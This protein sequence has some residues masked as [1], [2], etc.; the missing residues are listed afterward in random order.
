MEKLTKVEFTNLERIMFPV[1]GST[2]SQVIEYYIKIAP[3]I[4]NYL[5]GR[6]LT[7]KRF[8]GGIAQEGFYEK[9]APAGTPPWVNTFRNASKSA[10]RDVN[11]IIC[12]DLDTLIWLANLAALE[13]NITLSKVDSYENPDMVFIDMDPE[14]P[15]TFQDTCQAAILLKEKLDSLDFKSYIK[16]SGKK[17]VHVVIPI[18]EKYS[19]KQTRGFVHTLGRYLAKE[20]DFIVSEFSRSREPGTIFIDYTLNVRGKTMA[21]PYSL[22]PEEKATVSTPLDW[23]ELK[24]GLDPENFNISSVLE[25]KGDPW[26]GLFDNKQLLAVE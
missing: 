14:P 24:K 23:K 13:I 22:R 5:R 12:N 18:F 15:R 21:C 25:R 1:I 3:K 9:D 20:S 6:P 2:K 19:F 4:L 8:P 11:Y 26:E 16:T 7:L 10:G 17:G